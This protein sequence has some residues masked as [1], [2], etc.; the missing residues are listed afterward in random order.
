LSDRLSGA[1]VTGP[2]GLL[3]ALT[4]DMTLEIAPGT[5]GLP[6]SGA[7]ILG[8][9]DP[10]KFA[11]AVTKIKDQLAASTVCKASASAPLTS[12]GSVGPVTVRS[13]CRT[14]PAP[15]W[16]TEDYKGTT[17][18][19]TTDGAGGNPT[20]AYATLDGAGVIG[21]GPDSIKAL[22]D[23]KAGQ[24]ITSNAGFTTAKEAVPSQAQFFYMDLQGVLQAAVANTPDATL[25]QAIAILKP[26][27]AV[28]IGTETAADH[29]HSRFMVL[30]P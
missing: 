3:S 19:F 8:I 29:T 9:N 4:G 26:I 21:I 27:K 15:E 23:A 16:Q 30:I 14:Q 2:D 17:I 18:N 10:S 12:G 24:N 7:L 5:P 11:A 1:G 22:I 6:V 13:G 25:S 20:V 28:A